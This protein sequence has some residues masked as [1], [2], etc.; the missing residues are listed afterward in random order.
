[1]AGDTGRGRTTAASRQ[2]S[3]TRDADATRAFDRGS[4]RLSRAEQTKVI[5]AVQDLGDDAVG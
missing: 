2:S 1:M 3:H 4:A 5:A